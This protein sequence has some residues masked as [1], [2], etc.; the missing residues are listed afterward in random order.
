MGNSLQPSP[1]GRKGKKNVS[2]IIGLQFLGAVGG[3]VT[4]SGTVLEIRDRT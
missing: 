2:S 4:P 3:N 1:F